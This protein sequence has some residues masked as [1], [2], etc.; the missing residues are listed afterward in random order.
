MSTEPV[1][2]AAVRASVTGHV[3]PEVLREEGRAEVRAK[4]AELHCADADTCPHCNECGGMWPCPTAVAAGLVVGPITR[5]HNHAPWRP[6]CNER[7][8]DGGQRRGACLNDDGTDLEIGG[9]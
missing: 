4:V 6:M 5:V 3:D 9:E 7:L 8:L 1:S 2:I